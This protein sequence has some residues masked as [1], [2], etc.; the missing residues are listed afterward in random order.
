P[1]FRLEQRRPS[2]RDVLKVKGLE[3]SYGSNRVLPGVDL[4]VRRGDR[5]AIIGPNGIGKSTLLKIIVG[6]V[7]ADA[8]AIDW[9][10]E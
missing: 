4:E 9:G 6:E 7:E 3:K 10:H 8:G 2:G 1:T 5:L